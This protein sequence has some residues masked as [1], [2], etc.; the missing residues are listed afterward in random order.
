MAPTRTLNPRPLALSVITLCAAAAYAP[1]SGCLNTGGGYSLMSEGGIGASVD[2]HVY[3]S[4]S[5]QPWTVTVRDTRTGQAFWSIDVPVGK[6]L[7]IQF[8]RGTGTDGQYTPDLMKWGLMEEFATYSNLANSLPVPGMDDRRLE[9]T[10]RAVPELPPDMTG[11]ANA[12][13]SVQVR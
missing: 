9:P 12:A 11:R 13:A 5:W 1:I 3:V 10:L 7:A 8:V 4:R 6:K 2:S